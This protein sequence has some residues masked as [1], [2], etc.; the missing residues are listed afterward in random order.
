MKAWKTSILCL[1][2]SAPALGQTSSVTLNASG[3]FSYISASATATVDPG[4][5]SG[6]DGEPDNYGSLSVDTPYSGP[7]DCYDVDGTS[8]GVSCDSEYFVPPGTYSVSAYFSGI[9]GMTSSGGACT[10]P[11]ASQSTTVNV[12]QGTT[13]T[14]SQPTTLIL[15]AGQA[16]SVPVTVTPEN[17]YGVAPNPT[18]NVTLY[19]GSTALANATLSPQSSGDPGESPPSVATISHS[20]KGAPPGK[21]SL[22]VKYP[23]DTNFTGSQTTSFTVTIEAA[24]LA[25]S[26]ALAVT[27]NPTVKGQPTT[28]VATVTPTGT[29]V[30]T[31]SVTIL[32][33]SSN[34]GAIPLTNGAA[35]LTVPANIPAGTYQ[36]QAL[37]SGDTYNIASTSNAV[38]LTVDAQTSTTT[39]VTV[40]PATVTAGATV[41]LAATVTPAISNVVPTGTVTVSANGTAVT[42]LTLNKGAASETVSTAGLTPGTYSIVGK[43]SGSTLATAS[44]SETDTVTIAPASSVSLAASPNPV[45]QGSITTLSATVKNGSGG[46]VTS[47]T[48]AFSYSGN[49]LG[50]ASV[51]SNGTAQLPIET[52][53]FAKGTYT[54]TATFSGSGSVPAATGTVSLVVD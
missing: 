41:Q 35:T 18:G 30:P 9:E 36:V 44:T 28:V 16:L 23:G 8:L 5:C 29:A 22:Y 33:G 1:L 48:V 10:I 4:D 26:T 46:A 31:G 53:S 51:M 47:G 37:Y 11:S 7:Q 2:A 17:T 34:L 52:T 21:Y 42:T 24:Q 3:G 14:T 20:T 6:E 45:A 25:T 40:S 49:A 38:E 12:P 13:S 32:A 39:A 19:Y 15:Q 50:S 54:I 43:Y 27:P